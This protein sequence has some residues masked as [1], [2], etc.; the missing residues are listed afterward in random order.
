MKEVNPLYGALGGDMIG[1]IYEWRNHKSKEF[2]LVRRNCNFT[3][4]SIMTLASAQAI[5]D[6]DF[7]YAMKYH[8]WGNNYPGA[9]YGGSFR[10][11]LET[12]VGQIAPYNSWGNGSAMRVSPVGFAFDTEA[13]VLSQA[14]K[15]ASVTHNHPEGIKG[16]QATAL[17]ILLA[18][19]GLDQNA[20]QSR[21]EHDFGYDLSTPLDDIRPTYRFDVSCQGTLPVA[22]RAF[23]EATSYEDAIRNAISVGGDSDTVAAITGG[24]ALAFFKEMPDTLVTEIERRLLPDMRETCE[25]FAK[26]F[27]SENRAFSKKLF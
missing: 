22:I 26:A 25:R 21:I 11:W 5:L 24:I 12:P 10:R 8:T 27:T 7:D 4:D 18:R 20:I 9:G 16:A 14:E 3:D 19:K 1:S 6:G 17:A 23:L 13:E 2:E 15:S